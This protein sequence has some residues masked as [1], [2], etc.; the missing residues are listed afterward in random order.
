MILGLTPKSIGLTPKS[1]GLTPQRSSPYQ[2]GVGLL[3]AYIV[4]F[5]HWAHFKEE[6][7]LYPL[8][9]RFYEILI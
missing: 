6:E 2:V 8:T 9:E 3:A 7:L 4:V 5:G 1:I